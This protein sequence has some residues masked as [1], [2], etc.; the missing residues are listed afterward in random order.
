VIGA[1]HRLFCDDDYAASTAYQRFWEIL[2]SG[3]SHSGTFPQVTAGGDRLWLE[4][5]Y[6]PVKSADGRVERVVKF[7][8]DVTEAVLAAQQ[9]ADI[10]ARGADSLRTSIETSEQIRELIAEAK[11]VIGNLND[12]SKNIETIVATI[13]AVADQTNLLALNAAIEAARAGEHG[14]GFAVV[15]G[16]VRQL[17]ARTSAATGE[18]AEVIRGNLDY[19][20]DIVQRIENAS[21][22]A[23]LGREQVRSVEAI[24]EEIRQ[25]ASHVLESVSSIPQH[26]VARV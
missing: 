15:A 11:A 2:R 9:T 3:E 22:V 13:S 7:A 6:F 25:G 17:A 10:A 24:V 1:H 4:A 8:T 26:A 19:T 14:R 12:E 5:S 16:E 18:I 23:D 21:R 20:G